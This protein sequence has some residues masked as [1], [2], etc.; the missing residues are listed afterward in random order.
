MKYLSE[1]VA[2]IP[3]ITREGPQ[4]QEVY[5]IALDSREVKKN[6]LFIAINGTYTDGH[7]YIDEAVRQGAI[8]VVC[9]SYPSTLEPGVSYI[10]VDDTAR[11]T[12]DIAS[13]FYE[14]PSAHVKLIGI[15]G[16]NGKTT[17]ATLL[18]H[19][20][21]K[22]GFNT[23]LMSTIKNRVNQKRLEARL[24][25]PNAI[26]INRLLKEMKDEGCEYC[27]MEVS[28]HAIAQERISGLKWTGG[29]FTNLSHDHLDYHKTFSNYLQ[30]KKGFFDRLPANA[31]A[32]INV[33]DANGAVMVQNT[34]ATIATYALKKIADFKAKI[35]EQHLE[36][37][38]LE[39][40][41]QQIGV[42]LCGEFNAYNLTAV[43][44]TARMLQLSKE[45]SLTLLSTLQP[46]E[47][48]FEYVRA[49]NGSIVIVDFAHSPD[50]L[51]HVL[52]TIRDLKNPQAR[53]I[54]LVGAGGRKDKQKRPKMGE[55]AASRSEQVILTSD[56][57]RDEDPEQ[58]L[59][60]MLEGV[61]AERQK[62]VLL[63]VDRY[64][65]I[66]T[67]CMLAQPYDVVLVA[68]KGHENY[69]EIK[70]EIFYFSDKEV[71]KE[72]MASI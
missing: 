42:Q 40:D 70:G 62:N 50:S 54:T 7:L 18:Y 69:Q 11:A 6:T 23:G 67:A 17:V 31:F 29:V 72:L 52:D 16:T 30:A 68:G 71:V 43:Y 14:N 8:A 12:G 3:V 22:A 51:K 36:G 32:L 55:I 38:L 46:V 47:G 64:Q 25:T 39:M 20:F 65:A 41:E 59:Q 53:V 48:R 56:N 27:F 61:P 28:S 24:T 5:H 9:E 45:R 57:P 60:E 21:I 26:E 2:D 49:D 19:M 63:Q 1:I 10:K 15:T 4:E 66:K 58:I 33:D 44:G 13:A 37:M 34:P 35:F